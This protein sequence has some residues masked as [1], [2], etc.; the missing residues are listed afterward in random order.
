MQPRRPEEPHAA[1]LFHAPALY[2]ESMSIIV[3]ANQ[4]GGVGKTAIA[5]HLAH[6]LLRELGGKMLVVDADPG[7]SV[8]KHF[9]RR[10]I[11][12]PPYVLAGGAQPDIH[13]RL[14]ALLKAGGFDHCIVDCPA[15]ASNVTRSALRI[16]DLV[17]V[18]VQPS[19]CD[20]DAAEEL[21]PIL[22]DISEVRK[23]LQVMVIISRKLPGNNAYSKEART[24]AAAVF[25]V[26]G[27][28]VTVARQEISN[29]AEMVRA[30]TDGKTIFEY[31]KCGVSC[32]EFNRLTEE[33]AAC[34]NAVT[35]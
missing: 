25:Q 24:A 15:G 19:F 18:P 20:F 17:I 9:R 4:K 1:L 16:A 3:T 13:S 5:V 8:Y 14:P 32:M 2:S 12:D 31:G 30:Y 7:A 35:A 26:E 11:G 6:G 23:E 34:L 22:Q 21:L 33:V 28:N 29:R 27:V 10:E